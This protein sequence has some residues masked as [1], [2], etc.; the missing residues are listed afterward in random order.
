MRRSARHAAWLA[1]LTDDE[2]RVAD[3]AECLRLIL[4][5][6]GAC[7]RAAMFLKYHLQTQH[8]IVGRAVIGYVNDGTDDLFSSHAWYDIR[9]RI[10][11]IAL[12]R[13]LDPSVQKP[14]PV[15]IL[16]REVAPGW[17]GW[18]YHTAMTAEGAAVIES[19]RGHP[20]SGAQVRENEALHAHMVRTAADDRLIRS[21]LDAAPD[22]LTYAV[23]AGR[24]R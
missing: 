18:T 9:G 14:G 19:I 23:L 12:S 16:G 11:D 6:D 20:H 3:A 10:T 17:P 2:R 8:G 4:P 22:G 15:L 21:Y 24:M 5:A 1:G 13:P 7:Y